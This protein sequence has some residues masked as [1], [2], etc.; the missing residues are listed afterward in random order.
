MEE[1]KVIQSPTVTADPP[2]P[3]GNV[4]L[5]AEGVTKVFPGTV[6]LDHVDFNCYRGKVNVLIGENGAG[7]STLM[8]I[9]AGVERP[10][11]GLLLLE[12]KPVHFNDP[13]DA[14]RQG[15]GI[16]Y[17]KLDLFPNLTVVENIFMAREITRGIAIDYKAQEKITRDLMARLEQPIEPRDIVGDLQHTYL[18][19]YRPPQGDRIKWRS[20]QLAITGLK[21]VRVRAR[22][23]Y[24]PD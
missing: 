17:Q 20:I 15:I 2:A 14:S 8:K 13:L 18:L 19:A 23:G 9:I 11:E 22:E 12:G 1:E 3:G 16:I 10:T 6:A 24:F 21:G 4:V 7:K 5:R